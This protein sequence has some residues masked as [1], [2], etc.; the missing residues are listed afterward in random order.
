MLL[1]WARNKIINFCIKVFVQNWFCRNHRKLLTL[2]LKNQFLMK[3]YLL[4]LFFVVICGGFISAQQRYYDAAAFYLL[5]DVQY[6][7]TSTGILYF[8]E[9]GS[10]NKIKSTALNDYNKYDIQR[11]ANGYPIK[12]ITDHE[13]ILLE[14]YE[15]GRLSKRTVRGSSNYITTYSHSE[16]SSSISESNPPLTKTVFLTEETKHLH[17]GS[18]EVSIQRYMCEQDYKGNW[19]IRANGND[20]SYRTAVYYSTM[21]E[22]KQKENHTTAIEMIENPI[23]V[24]GGRDLFYVP[25]KEMKKLNKSMKLKGTQFM[26]SL[27][28]KELE[29]TFYGE[30]V[31]A[32]FDFTI[33]PNKVE[34]PVSYSYIYRS[35]IF[36]PDKQSI[37]DGDFFNLILQEL[38]DAGATIH[39]NPSLWQEITFYYKGFYGT[40][41]RN[42]QTMTIRF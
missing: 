39:C 11:N 38:I 22:H 6:L 40:I 17:G 28:F 3:K 27:D 21:I 20:K 29:R 35:R 19:F 12:I 16:S 8:N 42:K 23:F 5:G 33:D 24:E 1:Q 32:S 34:H 14:Y 41:N 18:F 26:G 13:E 2:I 31:R 37:Y 4:T 30:K 10:L 7:F 15:G 9:D 25:F 36:Y